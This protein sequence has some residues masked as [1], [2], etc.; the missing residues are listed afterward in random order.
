MTRPTVCVSF[1]TITEA[2]SDGVAARLPLKHTDAD[3][4]AAQSCGGREIVHTVTCDSG[5]QKLSKGGHDSLM[6]RRNPPP[7][8]FAKKAG[9]SSAR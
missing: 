8:V 9:F 2:A 4:F 3:E 1:A 7:S 6:R 5:K